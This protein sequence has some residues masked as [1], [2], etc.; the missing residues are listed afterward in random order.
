MDEFIKSQVYSDYVDEANSSSLNCI[1]FFLPFIITCINNCIHFLIVNV[2]FPDYT[3]KC[4][5]I[6][7]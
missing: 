5:E 1:N 2:P 6:V 3:R 4:S 7:K